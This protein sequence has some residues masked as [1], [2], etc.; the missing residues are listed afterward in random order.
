MKLMIVD[1]HAGARQMIREILNL[2]GITFYEC[3]TGEEA[4]TMAR[5]FRPDWITMD[6]HLPG[7]NG[8]QAATLIEYESPSSRVIIVTSDNHPYLHRMVDAVGAMA[9]VGKE[10][11]VELRTLL[12]DAIAEKKGNRSYEN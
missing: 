7:L 2:P 9:Q 3:V 10:N 12:A 5:E 6:V 8:F 11:L 1:D 4:V